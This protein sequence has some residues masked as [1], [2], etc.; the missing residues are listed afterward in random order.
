[1]CNIV[2]TVQFVGDTAE[3]C[4]RWG[5][6]LCMIDRRNGRMVARHYC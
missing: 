3:T 2:Q 5:R 6:A 1:M 4:Y